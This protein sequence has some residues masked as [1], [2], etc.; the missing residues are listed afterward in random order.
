MS[1]LKPLPN[2]EE[3]EKRALMESEDPSARIRFIKGA[4]W[5]RSQSPDVAKLSEKLEEKDEQCKRLQTLLNA[6]SIGNANILS[7]WEEWV[8][9]WSK[10]FESKEQADE[11]Y[12]S[13]RSNLATWHAETV[14]LQELGTER[15][16]KLSA[17]L[18]TMKEAWRLERG[19]ATNAYTVAQATIVYTKADAIA[20]GKNM[21]EQIEKA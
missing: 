11:V 17:D 13:A 2:D 4:K 20:G 16:D 18:E 21:T 1:E 10:L 7:H 8:A 6:W 19:L 12:H 5:M 15:A 14:R 9:R 3:I